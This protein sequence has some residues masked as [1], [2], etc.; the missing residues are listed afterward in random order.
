MLKLNS[1]QVEAFKK[2][3]LDNFVSR[4]QEDLKVNYSIDAKT[5]HL[6]ELVKESNS[7][8]ILSEQRVFDYI[9]LFYKNENIADAIKELGKV[10]RSEYVKEAIKIKRLKEELL[11]L[12]TANR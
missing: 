5:E 9:F 12:N 6:H 2:L 7:F 1:K 3:S 11:K 4:V 10:L 8:Y